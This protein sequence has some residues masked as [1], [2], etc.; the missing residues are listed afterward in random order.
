MKTLLVP[1]LIFTLCSAP[2]QAETL[3]RDKQL[4]IAAGAPAWV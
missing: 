3:A 2:A 1:I 4:H